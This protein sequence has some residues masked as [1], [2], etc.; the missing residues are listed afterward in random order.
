[1]VAGVCWRKNVCEHLVR[2]NEHLVRL[3][4]I[5]VDGDVELSR[6]GLRGRKY[7]V[8]VKV[9]FDAKVESAKDLD[10]YPDQCH[11]DLH[12]VSTRVQPWY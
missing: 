8:R 12:N 9:S 3:K 10:P 5:Y 7:R 6:L 11:T 2:L 1:L 4:G